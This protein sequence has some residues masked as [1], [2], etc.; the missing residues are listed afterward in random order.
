MSQADKELQLWAEELLDYFLLQEDSLD[1]PTLAPAPPAN[2]NLDRP[3]DDQG[4]TALHWAAAMG[5]MEVVKD[6]I[7]RGASI[8]AQSK[9]GE[10]PL[11]RSVTFKRSG[12]TVG[13]ESQDNVPHISI[14]ATPLNLPGASS[15]TDIGLSDFAEDTSLALGGSII[16]SSEEYAELGKRLCKLWELKELRDQ[17]KSEVSRNSANLLEVIRDIA[18]LE[19]QITRLKEN[20]ALSKIALHDSGQKCE[21]LEVELKRAKQQLNLH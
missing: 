13:A 5:D 11:M 8:E 4:H 3:I 1:A 9:N 17:A 2:A 16:R 21:N 6:L 18:G 7:R 20:E 15:S 19:E 14:S 12:Q 10:T